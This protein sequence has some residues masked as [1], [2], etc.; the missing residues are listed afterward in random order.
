MSADICPKCDEQ[1]VRADECN[2]CGW[3]AI[4]ENDLRTLRAQIH[5][6]KSENER[7]KNSVT[8]AKIAL[9]F[10]AKRR[11]GSLARE[12]ISQIENVEKA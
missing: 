10:Y 5:E 12:T 2:Y 4:E 7:L 8:I 11:D 3:S 9:K 6:V 1:A